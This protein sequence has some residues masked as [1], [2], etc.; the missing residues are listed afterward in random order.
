MVR[1]KSNTSLKVA[2]LIETKILGSRL[3]TVNMPSY[4]QS[5]VRV[6]DKEYISKCQNE[7]IEILKA[8]LKLRQ[9]CQEPEL[10]PFL[11]EAILWCE[12]YLE[13]LE[14]PVGEND[15]PEKFVSLKDIN[16]K[17]TLKKVHL[18]KKDDLEINA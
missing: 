5:L 17:L 15:E 10:M 13:K 11:K 3:P 14:N 16:N 1:N 12:Q 18:D 8:D 9:S 6:S 2:D 7:D 4:S